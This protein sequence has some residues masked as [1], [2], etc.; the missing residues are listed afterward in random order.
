MS[1]LADGVGLFVDLLAVEI[2]VEAGID[3][4]E[5]MF[6][7]DGE[8]PARAARGVVDG[9]ELFLGELGAVR[10]EHQLDHEAD[11]VAWR[12]ELPG[13]FVAGFF[14]LADEILEDRAHAV[15]V[16]GGGRQVGLS[17]SSA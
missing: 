11:D 16:H 8:H 6:L 15:V 10:L 5:E 2:H 3:R 1:A 4:A 9:D 13:G 7:G 14:E 17:E 12:V